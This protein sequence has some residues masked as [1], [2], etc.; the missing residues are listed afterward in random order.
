M[1]SLQLS[2]LIFVTTMEFKQKEKAMKIIFTF[3]L[4]IIVFAGS[5]AQK[6]TP[7]AQKAGPVASA[8]MSTVQLFSISKVYPNPVKDF[9]TIDIRSEVSEIVQLS[10]FNILGTEVKKWE[11]YYLN[12]GE[13][14]FK[15]DLSFLKTGI[16]ILKVAGSKQACSQVIKKS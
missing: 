6:T 3:L 1:N 4:I 8:G 15:I 5:F 11:S 10:L 13:Q 12:Q 16:Y 14:Q 7:S 2:G 9:V